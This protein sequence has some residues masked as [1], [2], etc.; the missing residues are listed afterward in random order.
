[1]SP[2]VLNNS[3]SYSCKLPNAEDKSLPAEPLGAR[4][5]IPFAAAGFVNTIFRMQFHEVFHEGGKPGLKQDGSPM[6]THV[7]PIISG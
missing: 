7:F 1:M 6:G 5:G 3:V 2:V 4:N